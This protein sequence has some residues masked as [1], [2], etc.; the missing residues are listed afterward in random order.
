MSAGDKAESFWLCD[1]VFQDMVY[2]FYCLRSTG[3][4]L[5]DPPPGL[6]LYQ[7]FFNLNAPKPIVN[8]S[9]TEAGVPCLKTSEMIQPE[10]I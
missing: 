10:P 5:V 7:P 8:L 9:F 2:Q 3:S 4:V 6:S 1:L